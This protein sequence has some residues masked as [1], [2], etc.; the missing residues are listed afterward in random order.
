MNNQWTG[1]PY[2]K[3]NGYYQGTTTVPLTPWYDNQ[4]EEEETTII[5]RTKGGDTEEITITKR[6]RKTN[7]YPYNPPYIPWHSPTITLTGNEQPCLFDN[8]NW[9]KSPVAFLSCSCPK[10]SVW[11]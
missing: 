4:W 1:D 3:I 8:W 7:P 11:I 10:H 6:K 2:P 9:E 5:K